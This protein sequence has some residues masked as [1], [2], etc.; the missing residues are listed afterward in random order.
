MSSEVIARVLVFVR[1]ARELADKGHNLRA[2][3]IF[4][5]AV[6]AARALGADNLV[7][8]DMQRNQAAVLRNYA[9]SVHNNN[10][11]VDPLAVA[12]YRAKSIALL[13][14]A[15]AALE[16]QRVVGTLLEGK[17]TAAEEAWVS[18]KRTEAGKTSALNAAAWAPL[19]GYDIYVGVAHSIL[20]LL[21]NAWLFAVECSAAQFEAFAQHVVNAA[22][23]M[24]L[25]R[26]RGTMYMGAEVDFVNMFSY[27]MDNDLGARG[28]NVSLVHLMTGAWQKLQQSGVLET[29]GILDE[30]RR[31][32]QSTASDHHNRVAAIRAAMAAPGLRTCALAGCE[33]K[34]A[35]PQHF[36]SCAACR[37]VVYCCREHQVE[38]WPAHKAACK[39]ACK[40]K[41]ASS[42]AGA[43]AGAA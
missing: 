14:A 39:A 23:L 22:D 31:Y 9:A 26:S 20:C 21:Y 36:K 1:K 34:E 41:A 10:A 27:A 12:A 24:Q 37:T 30:V 32:K 17:C 43:G 11:A 8:V 42:D 40:A 4:G 25:P 18:A 5:R 29:R 28:V 33:A 7:A 13:S 38:G 6:E 16:R 19:A 2:A 3:E 15:A 35:H